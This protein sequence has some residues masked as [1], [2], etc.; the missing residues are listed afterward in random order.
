MRRDLHSNIEVR[1]LLAAQ[2]ITAETNSAGCDLAGF[3]S[4]DLLVALGA[5]TNIAASPTP[6]WELKLEESDDDSTYSAVTSANDVLVGSNP[7]VSAPDASGIFATIDAAAEDAI[8][9]RI[10]YIGNKRYVR[11]TATA[12]QTPGSTPI[13]V[14][15]LLGKPALAPT[16]DT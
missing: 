10:G 2:A 12:T 4:V 15:A 13:A 11:I 5:V 1:Q 14:L 3:E 6:K 7:R 16:T 8:H 9:F